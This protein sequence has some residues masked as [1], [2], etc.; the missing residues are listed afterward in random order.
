MIVP[1]AKEL[2]HHKIFGATLF[3]EFPNIDEPRSDPPH[4]QQLM[5]GIL[6]LR[7]VDDFSEDFQKVVANP[8]VVSVKCFLKPPPAGVSS[9]ECD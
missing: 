8:G 5:S 9:C 7:L 4:L 3:V 1:F 2:N 6:V